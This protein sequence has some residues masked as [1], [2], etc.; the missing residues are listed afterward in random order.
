MNICSYSPTKYLDDK[1]YNDRLRFLFKNVC[2]LLGQGGGGGSVSSVGLSMPS[3]FSVANSPV[4]TSGTL[5]VTGAGT[6]SQYIRGD[7]SLATT[8]VLTNEWHL[9]GNTGTTPGTHFLGTTDNVGLMFKANNLQCGYINLIRASTSFGDRALLAS[10]TGLNNAAFGLQALGANTNGLFNSAFGSQAL[11]A[12]T[13]G[14]VNSAFGGNSMQFNISGSDNSAFGAGALDS[15]TTG[16]KNIGL[17]RWAGFYSTTVSNQVF[18]NSLD[19]GGYSQD[20]AG[21]PFYSVQNLT[22]NSQWSRL[23]G[24]IGI[25]TSSPSAFLHLP[26]GT[27]TAAT[28]P[29]KL[30]SGTNLTSPEAGA[31]EWDGTNL[32][33]TQTSG[34]TRKT[35]AYTSDIPTT[36]SGS[37]TQTGDGL[38]TSFNIAHGLSGAPSYWTAQVASLAAMDN[39]YVTADAT[40]IT[41]NYLIS[42]L[43]GSSLTWTWEAKL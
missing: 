23:N 11:I 12:N 10:S 35:I 27:A 24:K 25:N 37:S 2:F 20:I 28:A 15:N 42:P 9:S 17:G 1:G 6:T 30:T 39:F 41:I 43:A 19:R 40:N 13:T 18:I 31:I 33:A 21:S 4:T 38:A 36:A 16:D 26:A 32:F 34:P 8:P 29:I 22:V 7:G 5:A 14:Q 3:A